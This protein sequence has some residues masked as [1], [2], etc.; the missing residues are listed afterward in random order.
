MGGCT[1]VEAMVF[2]GSRKTK[3][4]QYCIK[5]VCKV[6]ACDTLTRWTEEEIARGKPMKS[7]ICV[8]VQDTCQNWQVGRLK[9]SVLSGMLESSEFDN[10]IPMLL[11]T[12]WSERHL[13]YMKA[14][15]KR[16]HLAGKRVALKLDDVIMGSVWMRRCKMNRVI[17]TQVLVTK[18]VFLEPKRTLWTMNASKMQDHWEIDT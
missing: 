7:Q 8:L 4:R 13:P 17:G 16:V 11:G 12:W 9:W 18:T 6:S 10:K 3:E 15:K 14:W 2:D 5:N 1:N